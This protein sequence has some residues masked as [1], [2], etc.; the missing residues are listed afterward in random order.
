MSKTCSVVV[1]M[2]KRGVHH[3]TAFPSNLRFPSAYQQKTNLG[4]PGKG[5]NLVA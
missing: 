3:A 2:G 4:F 1:G 5:D